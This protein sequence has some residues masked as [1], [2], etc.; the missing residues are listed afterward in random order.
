M[1]KRN[2]YPIHK[3]NICMHTAYGIY[4][5]GIQDI[6]Y[7]LNFIFNASTLSLC[8]LAEFFSTGLC[9]AFLFIFALLCIL[10]RSSHPLVRLPVVLKCI[11]FIHI[12]TIANTGIHPVCTKYCVKSMAV[13]HA[14]HVIII[15]VK[16]YE[17]TLSVSCRVIF[18][19]AF[20]LAFVLALFSTYNK[21][22]CIL[23][24]AQYFWMFKTFI[25]DSSTTHS[26]V[27]FVFFSI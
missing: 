14:L 2:H 19:V 17:K 11:H 12:Y 16:P 24:L 22:K 6:R 23:S 13:C 1:F 26:V 7:E 15:I 20:S 18:S 21:T 9:V 27:S 25:L 10:F 5:I 8:N 4:T 3:L